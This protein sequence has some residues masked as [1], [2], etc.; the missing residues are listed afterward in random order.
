[1]PKVS[2]K[3]KVSPRRV[4]HTGRRPRAHVIGPDVLCAQPKP[5]RKPRKPRVK[6]PPPIIKGP[7]IVLPS[8]P[9][10]GSAVRAMASSIAATKL[11]AAA[12]VLKDE[13]SMFKTMDIFQAILFA[14]GTVFLFRGAVGLAVSVLTIGTFVPMLIRRGIAKWRDELVKR[15]LS[16]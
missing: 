15:H 6:R 11:H 5:P 8:A 13:A 3:K 7:P 16:P 2:T 10:S 12:A 14:G 4:P 1:M 9:A